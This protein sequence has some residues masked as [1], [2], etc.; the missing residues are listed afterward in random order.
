MPQSPQTDACTELIHG[1]DMIHPLIVNHTDQNHTLQL[2][3]PFRTDFR[4]FCFI[5]SLN[6]CIDIIS[7]F[8]RRHIRVFPVIRHHKGGAQLLHGAFQFLQIPFL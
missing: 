6:G 2:T 1:I 3:H 8:L 4:F 5:G 7:E